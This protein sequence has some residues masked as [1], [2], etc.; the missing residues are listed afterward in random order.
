MDRTDCFIPCCACACG[1]IRC[2]SL[3]IEANTLGY[4]GLDYYC[5]MHC[6][7]TSAS[8]GRTG[9]KRNRLCCRMIFITYTSSFQT[10]S[11][12]KFVFQWHHSYTLLH[13][14]RWFLCSWFGFAENGWF[15]CALSSYTCVSVWKLKS[16]WRNALWRWGRSTT[17]TSYWKPLPTF[18]DASS[19]MGFVEQLPHLVLVISLRLNPT[20]PSVQ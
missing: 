12:R 11:A 4:I 20:Q 2:L 16:K 1:V 15:L 5:P 9:G 17:N 14:L 3:G 13:R 6:L 18:V 8:C 10:S 19:C 7:G